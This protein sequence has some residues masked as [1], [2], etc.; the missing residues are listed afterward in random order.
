MVTYICDRCG[1][2]SNRKTN[3]RTHVFRK[4][5]CSPTLSNVPIQSVR[6]KYKITMKQTT[7]TAQS[8]SKQSLSSKQLPSSPKQLPLS[9]PKSPSSSKQ[10]SSNKKQIRCEYCHK[11]YSRMDYLRTHQRHH[12]SKIKQRQQIQHSQETILH[13]LTHLL[14]SIEQKQGT[15]TNTIQT[16]NNIKNIYNNITINNYG[17]ENISHLSL[18]YFRKLIMAGPYGC[19]PKLVEKIH[20][21]PEH[22]ENQNIKLSNKKLPYIKNKKK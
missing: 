5:V 16:I 6:E 10:T 22:P 2:T 11:T 3:F 8:E 19:I 12:C 14:E 9:P 7:S 18:E 4:F 15:T 17:N 13:K 20:F 21:D 1:Y